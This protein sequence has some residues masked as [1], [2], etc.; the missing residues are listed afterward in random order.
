MKVNKMGKNNLL[1]L[2]FYHDSKKKLHV[3]QRLK[4]V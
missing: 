4:F 3:E 2:P 1:V